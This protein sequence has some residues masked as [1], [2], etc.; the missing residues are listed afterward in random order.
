M[1]TITG[2]D[3]AKNVDT[4]E[5]PEGPGCFAESKMTMIAKMTSR[6]SQASKPRNPRRTMKTTR[7]EHNKDNSQDKIRRV[8]IWSDEQ[9]SEEST[10]DV[11]TN[12]NTS[13]ESPARR[14]PRARAR[15]Q[16]QSKRE[17]TARDTR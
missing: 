17:D 16:I 15:R 4:S 11:T 10:R 9:E 8:Q 13:P 3:S 1:K 12:K 2:K 14:E 5:G 6:T 7:S